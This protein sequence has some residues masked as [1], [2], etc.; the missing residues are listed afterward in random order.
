[1]RTSAVPQRLAWQTLF[2]LLFLSLCYQSHS[3]SDEKKTREQLQQLEV[4]IKRIAV[5][6][7]DATDRQSALQAQLRKVEID[8]GTLQ[9]DITENEQTFE[10]SAKE[11]VGLQE[12]RSQHEKARDEQ[13]AR[14]AV[15][16]KTAWQVG[17]Q[18]QVKVLLNQESPHTVA[19]SLGYYRYFFQARNTLIAE[20]RNN[21]RAISG[22]PAAHRYHSGRAGSPWPNSG[23]T[24][25]QSHRSPGQPKTGY[26]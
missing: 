5:E 4:E 10:R 15:E 23:R 12:Q 11:L 22:A 9:R 3:Q 14:I 26:D 25:G 19:R 2:A 13:Q 17:R 1:M 8:L 24:T 16:L 6:I 21:L 18:G 20:Y 7:S